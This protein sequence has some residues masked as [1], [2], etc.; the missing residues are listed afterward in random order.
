MLVLGLT[1][2]SGSGKGV[3]G[4]VFSE[5]GIPVLDTDAVYHALIDRPT[6]CTEELKNAFGDTILSCNGGV[7]RRRLAAIVFDP[8]DEK[9]EKL[10]LLNKIT[11]RYVLDTCR[12][13]LKEQERKGCR[14][15]VIDAPLL[16]E[17][18]FDKEC[19]RVIAVLAPRQTRLA[20]IMLRDSLTVAAAEERLSSQQADAF[21]EEK[22]DFLLRNDDSLAALKEQACEILRNLDVL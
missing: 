17:S 1:G 20:R 3:V 18:G 12:A 2:P 10:L 14:A 19:D 15:S 16:C 9:K 5:K 21:Y 4:K 22:A 11:H 7:D 8:A 6:S 13:W